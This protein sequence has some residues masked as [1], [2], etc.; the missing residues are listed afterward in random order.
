M[1]WIIP[2]TVGHSVTYHLGGLDGSWAEAGATHADRT[3]WG[4][5]RAPRRG[6]SRARR[7]AAEPVVAL[8][9]DAF[10]NALRPVHDARRRDALA[11]VRDEGARGEAARVVYLLRSVTQSLPCVEVLR[12]ELRRSLELTCGLHVWNPTGSN[13]PDIKYRTFGAD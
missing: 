5:G 10:E 1:M 4:R 12:D 11:E 6:A 8:F 7:C 13:I 3:C 2:A 9:T